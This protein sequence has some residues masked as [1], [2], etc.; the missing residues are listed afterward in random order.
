MPS[1]ISDLYFIRNLTIAQISQQPVLSS[2]NDLIAINEPDLLIALLGVD[3]YNAFQAG[4]LEDPIDP[5]WEAL[6]N[7]GEYLDRRNQKCI[8]HGLANDSRKTS[9][10]ANYVYYNYMKQ[11]ASWSAGVGEVLPTMINGSRFAG[12]NKMVT[13]W[14]DMV[15]SNLAM[16]AYLNQ[17]KETYP[18]W[19]P[20]PFCN[21]L[22]H[23]DLWYWWPVGYFNYRLGSECTRG[24]LFTKIN[25]MNI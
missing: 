24:D 11:T 8:W 3:L 18:E 19:H 23:F 16:I 9:V 4:L 1:I 13:A 14:N 20:I 21:M 22:W 17:H 7:G 25:S 5:K 2:I 6:L 10:I 15:D 12:A